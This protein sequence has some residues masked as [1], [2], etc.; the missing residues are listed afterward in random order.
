MKVPGGKVFHLGVSGDFQPLPRGEGVANTYSPIYLSDELYRR[1]KDVPVDLEVTYSVT[2]MTMRDFGDIDPMHGR[3]QYSSIGLCTSGLNSAETQISV[4]CLQPG[5]IPLCTSATLKMS[6]SSAANPAIISCTP[7]YAP[8]YPALIPD[9][10]SRF[11]ANLPF[12]DPIGLGRY[13]V[14]GRTFRDL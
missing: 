12:R 7:N 10:T 1:Y 9:G 11:S 8:V 13:P 3:K 4:R 5:T 6:D 2:K 14:Q